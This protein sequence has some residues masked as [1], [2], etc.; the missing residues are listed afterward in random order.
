MG[1]KRV[2]KSCSNCVSYQPTKHEGVCKY[3]TEYNQTP[4]YV[5]R[6]FKCVKWF[7]REEKTNGS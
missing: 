2:W 4:V 5:H 7:T 1:K 6:N 3:L